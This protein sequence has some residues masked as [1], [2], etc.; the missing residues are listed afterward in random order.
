MDGQKL[1]QVDKF[2]YLGSWITDDGRCEVEIKSRIAMAKQAFNNRREL[3]TRTLKLKLKKKLVKTL[4]WT[5]LLY[6]AETW[7]LRK[8]D[9]TRLK[10]FEMWAW[11]KLEK[12]SWTDHVKNVE[13]LERVGERRLLM[14]TIIKR[15]KNW[16]GH[17]LRGE[18]LMTNEGSD[19]RK[20]CGKR[21]R[22]RQRIGML[23]SLQED[24]IYVTMKRKASD[25]TM[26]RCWTP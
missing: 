11:R 24:G 19:G 6:G 7:T 1:D 14:S 17:V 15:K 2:K 22:G 21:G 8:V 10:A 3:L 23:D 12:I 4:I 20:A 16:I 25:R 5:V 26:W 9:E 13:V 18:G